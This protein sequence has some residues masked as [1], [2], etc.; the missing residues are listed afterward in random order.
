M[1]SRTNKPL[2]SVA[3]LLLHNSIVLKKIYG[4]GHE[5]C[6]KAALW[7]PTGSHYLLLFRVGARC[8]DTPKTFPHTICYL[9]HF[10]HSIMVMWQL[11]THSPHTHAAFVN[12]DTDD[13]DDGG[14]DSHAYTM[15]GYSCVDVLSNPFCCWSVTGSRKTPSLRC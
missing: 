6:N 7:M 10:L 11:C 3:Y 15:F 4:A 9:K 5:T 8:L 1:Y 2:L 14:G 12:N 13:D